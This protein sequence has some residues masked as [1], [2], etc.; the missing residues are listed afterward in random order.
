MEE[1]EEELKIIKEYIISNFNP[2]A[3]ILFGSFSRNCRK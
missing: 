1:I 3:I 2:L